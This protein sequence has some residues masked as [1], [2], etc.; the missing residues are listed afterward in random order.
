[1]EAEIEPKSNLLSKRSVL[2]YRPKV[3]NLRCLGVHAWKI[4]GIQF[5]EVPP[6]ENEIKNKKVL[7]S[8]SKVLLIIARSQ[9]NKHIFSHNM[10]GQ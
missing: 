2:K 3:T 1:M 9:P 8:S 6:M 10:R 5:P 7:C 4:G